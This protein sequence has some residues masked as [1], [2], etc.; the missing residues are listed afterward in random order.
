[1]IIASTNEA[2]HKVLFLDTRSKSRTA[3]NLVASGPAGS[4]VRIYHYNYSGYVV[5]DNDTIQLTSVQS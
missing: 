3:A 4:V 2:V 5:K 1:M